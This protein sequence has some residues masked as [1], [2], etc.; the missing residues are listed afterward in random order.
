MA[1]VS[2]LTTRSQ[3]ALMRPRLESTWVS[4]VRAIVMGRE[5]A[6]PTAVTTTATGT[7]TVAVE[8]VMTVITIMTGMTATG[9]MT[10]T[11][12]ATNTGGTVSGGTGVRPLLAAAVVVGV[13]ATR[14]RGAVTRAARP[15]VRAV[16][17]A[18]E[19]RLSAPV[20]L[21]TTRRPTHMNQVPRGGEEEVNVARECF[22]VEEVKVFV[23]ILS[24]ARVLYVFVVCSW[25]SRLDQP[26]KSNPCSIV[27]LA[28]CSNPFPKSQVFQLA[29][30]IDHLISK[31][32][33][34]QVLINSSLVLLVEYAPF[35]LLVNVCCQLLR[36][37]KFNCVKQP[38]AFHFKVRRKPSWKRPTFKRCKVSN[39]RSASSSAFIGLMKT[40]LSIHHSTRYVSLRICH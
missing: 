39:S 30:A 10:V 3:S 11:G 7:A 40:D 9:A 32:P 12:T 2:V 21:D 33:V 23:E 19:V 37:C 31:N 15:V 22:V 1:V 16:L 6:T 24:C 18:A 29:L 5:I 25:R 35:Y 4:A 17:L 14:P 8:I 34:V 28:I 38:F 13:P 36:L 27:T 20:R 26:R